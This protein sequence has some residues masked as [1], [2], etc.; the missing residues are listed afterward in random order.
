MGNTTS[1]PDKR[2]VYSYC[3]QIN[4][5]QKSKTKKSVEIDVSDKKCKNV[6]QLIYKALYY[7]VNNL[8]YNIKECT[9]HF[10]KKNTIKEI[11]DEICIKGFSSSDKTDNLVLKMIPTCYKP[12]Q[13]NIISLLN[14]G[15]IVIAGIIVD[16]DILSCKNIVSDTVIIT[17][18][19]DTSFK[20]RSIDSYDLV[21]F[22]CIDNF[23]EI[24]NIEIKC[25]SF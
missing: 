14:D 18:Y 20:V 25:P 15:N 24:W 19:N 22:K 9:N 17:G 23:V 3:K 5:Q 13:E 4:Y 11:I 10:I 12:T 8:G 2:F 16:N 21:P 7:K 1:S 6:V